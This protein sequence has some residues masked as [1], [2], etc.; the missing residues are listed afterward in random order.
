MGGINHQPCSEYDPQ[1]ILLSNSLSQAC[2]KFWSGNGKIEDAL[3]FEIGDMLDQAK[4]S[5]TQAEFEIKESLRLIETTDANMVKLLQLMEKRSFQDFS[6]LSKI[7]FEVFKEGLKNIGLMSTDE[8][9]WQSSVVDISKGGYQRMFKSLRARFHALSEKTQ[10]FLNVFKQAQE[11]MTK[12]DLQ[13]SFNENR[14]GEFKR[15]FGNLFFAWNETMQ[16]F[17]YSSIISLELWYLQHKF[18][19]LTDV[20]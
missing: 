17:Y 12:G 8:L 20:T 19:S 9:L 3:V 15:T 7:N 13:N 10:Q 11:L 16:V 5:L 4:F 1:A 14:F 2:A 6:S 18:G